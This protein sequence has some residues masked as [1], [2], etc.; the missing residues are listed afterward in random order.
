MIKTIKHPYGNNKITIIKFIKD[1]IKKSIKLFL[2]IFFKFE[3]SDEVIISSAVHAPWLS[4]KKFK[5]IYL[6]VKDLTLLDE[7]RAYTLWQ[8]VNNLK[9]VNGIILDIGCLLGGAGFIMSKSNLK[10]KTYLFDTF[11]GFKKDDGL[12]KK[13]VFKFGDITFVQ[14]QIKRLSLKNIKVFKSY[15]PKNLPF[16]INKI[17]VC[18]IDVNT[19]DATK[20]IFYFVEK[21]MIKNGIIIFDDYG[22]WGVDGIKKFI[23]SIENNYSKKFIFIKNYMGQCILIKK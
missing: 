3:N 12:H 11:S 16:R 8:A 6:K 13:E 20:K 22:I 21:K 4:D 7:P 15:F 10:G 17:K 23:S 2:S 18:H 14:K 19:Y 9:N 5:N 1:L